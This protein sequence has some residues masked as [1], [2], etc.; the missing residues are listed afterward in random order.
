ML[1]AISITPSV[2]RLN[3]VPKNDPIALSTSD[4]ALIWTPYRHTHG[5]RQNTSGAAARMGRSLPHQIGG[6]GI[7]QPPCRQRIMQGVGHADAPFGIA[8]V[9]P[10][11]SARQKSKLHQN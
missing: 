10:I 2:K 3:S 1:S 7:G 9:G 4:P 8:Q 5:P 6:G 11:P